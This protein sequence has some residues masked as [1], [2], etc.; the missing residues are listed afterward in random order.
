MGDQAFLVGLLMF[1]DHSLLRRGNGLLEDKTALMLSPGTYRMPSTQH[2]HIRVYYP[3]ASWEMAAELVGPN[4]TLKFFLI[5]QQCNILRVKPNG[6][7]KFD[8]KKNITSNIM[9]IMVKQ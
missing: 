3:N 8:V 9:G 2:T 7:A 1:G 4:K 5:H 6:E